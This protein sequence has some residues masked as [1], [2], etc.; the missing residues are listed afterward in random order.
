MCLNQPETSPPTLVCGKT[1][2]QHLFLVPKKVGGRCS[3]KW[4]LNIPSGPAD[5]PKTLLEH[6]WAA[7]AFES[8]GSF[9]CKDWTLRCTQANLSI[10]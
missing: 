9:Q 5:I 8:D 6:I 4:G 1:V 3:N 10:I 7:A 2:L